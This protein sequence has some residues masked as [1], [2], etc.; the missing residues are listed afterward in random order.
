MLCALP[1]L[2]LPS[3]RRSRAFSRSSRVRVIGNFT[4]SPTLQLGVRVFNATAQ[5]TSKTLDANATAA[6]RAH[7]AIE[8]LREGL[9]NYASTNADVT[10]RHAVGGFARAA[11]G[12]PLRA[13][14]P[15]A[16]CRGEEG[17]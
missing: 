11:D 16:G 6:D 3:R 8:K 4:G 5:G 10:A 1:I 7:A 2:W 13:R 17:R 9:A 15:G 12:D 14:H